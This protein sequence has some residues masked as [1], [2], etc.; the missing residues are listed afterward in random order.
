MPQILEDRVKG[1][2][3]SWKPKSNA[4]AIATSQLQKE[5]KLIKWSQ[6]LTKKWAAA[7][8]ASKSSFSWKE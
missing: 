8:A 7:N 2:E 5:G 1:I 3:K 6:K 4:Y